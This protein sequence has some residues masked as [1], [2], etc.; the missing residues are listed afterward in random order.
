MVEWTR[1]SIVSMSS[2]EQGRGSGRK[3][4]PDSA[5]LATISSAA[6]ITSSAKGG[7]G[8]GGDALEFGA[9]I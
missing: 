2:R 6:A 4:A 9:I 1:A 3:R 7:V 5:V 8:N